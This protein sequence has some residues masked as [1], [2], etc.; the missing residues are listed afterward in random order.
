[1]N[2]N[3]LQDYAMTPTPREAHLIRELNQYCVMPTHYEHFDITAYNVY[4]WCAAIKEFRYIGRRSTYH[5][6]DQLIRAHIRRRYQRRAKRY[7]PLIARRC[8]YCSDL[9]AICIGRR[10]TWCK[11]ARCK[12]FREFGTFRIAS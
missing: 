1:M 5:E 9:F 10:R 6:A 11:S 4:I 8:K 12:H 7:E 2:G 3:Q